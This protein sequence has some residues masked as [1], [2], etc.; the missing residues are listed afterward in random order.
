MVVKMNEVHSFILE[1]QNFQGGSAM[2][3]YIE[4]LLRTRHKIQGYDTRS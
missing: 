1:A 3:I 4:N 2:P